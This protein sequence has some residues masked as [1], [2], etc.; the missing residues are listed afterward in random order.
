MDR[1]HVEQECNRQLRDYVER[2]TLRILE[3]NPS[4][5]EIASRQ[6]W[7]QIPSIVEQQQ[8]ATRWSHVFPFP[9]YL[10]KCIIIEIAF[11]LKF[12]QS[13]W[14]ELQSWTC[15]FQWECLECTIWLS[16]SRPSF[17]AANQILTLNACDQWTCHVTGSTCC[18]SV[19][20]MHCEH[21][22]WNWNTHVQDWSLVHFSSWAVNKPLLNNLLHICDLIV[23]AAFNTNV[24]TSLI[25]NP[26]SAVAWMY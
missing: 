17:A 13:M 1:L 26:L 3:K 8:R 22:H 7:R 21:F 6:K 23:S 9:S 19:Q 15:I 4:I 10:L 18:R 16:T 20:F 12:V 11:Y 5:L 2:I 14:T 25:D 24:P